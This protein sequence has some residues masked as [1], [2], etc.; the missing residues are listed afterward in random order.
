MRLLVASVVA[1]S[2][3]ACASTP[4]PE[5]STPPADPAGGTVPAGSASKVHGEGE[6]CGGLAG[7]GCASGLYCSFSPDAMCGAADQTGTCEKVPEVCTEQYQPVCGCN[8]KTYSNVCDA[9]RDGVSV[10]R[11]GECAPPGAAPPAAPAPAAAE[12]VLASGAICG[13]RGVPGNCGPD[14]YCAYKSACGATDS[15]GVCTG[16][17]RICTKEYNPVCGCDGKTY[18]TACVAASA[19][20]SVASKG[21][22]PAPASRE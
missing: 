5:P 13:T 14:D 3:L 19:G 6:M 4:P 22:C 9:A 21:S 10:G 2:A 11:N 7:F 18:G 8:D 15:G 17:P 20:V 12:P 1:L 16:K